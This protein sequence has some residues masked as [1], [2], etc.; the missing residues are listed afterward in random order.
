MKLIL[1]GRNGVNISPDKKVLSI[2]CKDKIR[3][4]ETSDLR[5]LARVD[6]K[7]F[8]K[9]GRSILI[10]SV[11]FYDNYNFVL[12]T[13]QGHICIIHYAS[14][15]VHFQNSPEVSGW[16]VFLICRKLVISLHL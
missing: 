3:M 16:R 11:C 15:R 14:G 8:I 2:I 12:C 9:I 4:F 10:T 5:E 7:E 6:L 13:V 1:K